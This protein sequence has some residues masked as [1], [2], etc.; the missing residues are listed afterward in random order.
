MCLG[1]PALVVSAD[2]ADAQS[3]LVEISGVRRSANLAFVLD[4]GQTPES[5]IGQW[6]LLHVGFAMSRIDEEEARKTLEL[7]AV[8]GEDLQESPESLELPQP[9]PQTAASG[10]SESG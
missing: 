5:M 9:Q 3:A 7:L 4:E 1:I 8:L 10:L 2:Q 6:V